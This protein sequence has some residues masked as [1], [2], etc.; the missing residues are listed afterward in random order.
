MALQFTAVAG[1]SNSVQPLAAWDIHKVF[2]KGVEYVEFKGKDETVYSTMKVKFANADGIFEHT[3]FM[4]KVTDADRKINESSGRPMASNW[5]NFQFLISHLGEVLSPVV[6]EKNK[7]K[8]SSFDVT[9]VTGFKQFIESLNKILTPAIDKETNLKLIGD[10]NNKPKLPYYVA[11]RKSDNEAFMSNN[12]LGE[13]LFFTDFEATQKVKIQSA[14]PTQ[15]AD[16]SDFGSTVDTSDLN[17]IGNES[18]NDLNFDIDI[19]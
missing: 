3:V 19:D 10:K 2:F 7:G 1:T 13:K 15:M 14:K 5:D 4:P 11:L 16:N 6:W 9:T 8:M 17:E 12:F 18:I